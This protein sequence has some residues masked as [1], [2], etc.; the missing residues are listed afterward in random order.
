[1]SSEAYNAA[2]LR[3]NE[4][5]ARYQRGS[6]SCVVGGVTPGAQAEIDLL[7]AHDYVVAK[8]VNVMDGLGVSA[9]LE[10]TRNGIAQIRACRRT[11]V[12]EIEQCCANSSDD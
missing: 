3:L 2:M 8:T 1:M 9:I 10:P 12:Q 6:R 4:I 11:W 5:E 7:I